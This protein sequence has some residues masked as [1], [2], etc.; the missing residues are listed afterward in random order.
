MCLEMNPIPLF[1]SVFCIFTFVLVLRCFLVWDS[2]NAQ[3]SLFI[4]FYIL[5][6]SLKLMNKIN[7]FASFTTLKKDCSFEIFFVQ[8]FLQHRIW[9]SFGQIKWTW[10]C[11]YAGVIFCFFLSSGFIHNFKSHWYIEIFARKGIFFILPGIYLSWCKNVY[12]LKN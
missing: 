7:S 9:Q 11:W 4:H 1:V 2:L 5:Y 10:R 12:I 6:F 3:T 8:V